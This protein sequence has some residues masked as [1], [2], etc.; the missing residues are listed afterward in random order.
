MFFIM[1]IFW[2][3]LAQMS[4]IWQKY[5]GCACWR[6]FQ[7]CVMELKA[8]QF[9]QTS[10]QSDFFLCVCVKNIHIFPPPKVNVHSSEGWTTIC[11]LIP[12]PYLA[13]YGGLGAG[14][15]LTSVQRDVVVLARVIVSA[16][17]GLKR[18]KKRRRS[19]SVC[20]LT[21]FPRYGQLK[22]MGYIKLVGRGKKGG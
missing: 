21:F 8:S 3:G 17:L 2:E 9:I 19:C 1:G 15:G 6:V 13:L 22:G 4:P 7:W 18:A 12:P 10:L 5:G 11:I 14:F 20:F 16:H